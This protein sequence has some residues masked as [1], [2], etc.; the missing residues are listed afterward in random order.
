MISNVEIKLGNAP[1]GIRFHIERVES[2]MNQVSTTKLLM[3]IEDLYYAVYARLNIEIGNLKLCQSFGFDI[4]KMALSQKLLAREYLPESSHLHMIFNACKKILKSDD[5]CGFLDK[6]IIRQN[7]ADYVR[8]A[9]Q[10]SAAAGYHPEDQLS[11]HR[12]VQR[13]V[14]DPKSPFYQKWYG[15]NP[16]YE[17]APGMVLATLSEKYLALVPKEK[18]IQEQ[19]AKMKLATESVEDPAKQERKRVFANREAACAM[20]NGISVGEYRRTEGKWTVRQYV[21]EK[22]CV[23]FGFC[24]CSIKCTIKSDKPCPCNTRMSIICPTQEPD[25]RQTFAD[26]CAELAAAVFEGLCAVEHNATMFEMAMELK[27]GLDLFHEEVIGYRRS[28]TE[29]F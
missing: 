8:R 25:D 11:Y 6:E 19:E 18:G 4:R 16:I 13:L 17:S 12:Y 28:C 29:R 26:R 3:T 10:S 5:I 21:K 23:C 22:L 9:V 27:D 14:S 20:L 7:Q 1:N 2:E 15:L 24:S